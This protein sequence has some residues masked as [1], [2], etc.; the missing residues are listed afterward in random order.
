MRPDPDHSDTVTGNGDNL[1]ATAGE[2][3]YRS[4]SPTPLPEPAINAAQESLADLLDEE[5]VVI[6]PI[7]EP[8]SAEDE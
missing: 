7:P 1:Q 5:P 2:G 3:A 6:E 8:V 4:E